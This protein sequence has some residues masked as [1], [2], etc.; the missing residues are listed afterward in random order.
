MNKVYYLANCDTCLRIIKEFNLADAC[1]LQDIKKEPITLRQLEGLKN[2][3]GSCE[4]LF[5][6]RARKYKSMGLA[7]QELKEA[8]YQRLILEEYTFLKRPVVVLGDEIF[9]GSSAK[10]KE[11]L[12][13]ALK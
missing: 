7:D 9:I 6:R 4:N 10:S 8:D 11:A 2:R 1:E 13:A 12:K 5:S 3:A